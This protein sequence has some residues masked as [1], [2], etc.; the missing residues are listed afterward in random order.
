ML[1]KTLTILSLAGLVVSVGLWGVSYWNIYVGFSNGHD[2]HIQNGTVLFRWKIGYTVS[3]NVECRMLGFDNL[4]TYWLPA[5]SD[6]S[7]SGVIW[8][9]GLRNS[10]RLPLWIPADIFVAVLS[11][12]S[13]RNHQ[14]LK[15]GLC[16]KCGYD[17]RASTE[18][19]PE[20]GTTF[21]AAT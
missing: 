10:L 8:G 20:C 11:F 18:R 5:Y 14:R 12:L 17:L 21:K 7:K 4:D 3:G 2:V 15:L 9:G 16:L 19:C 1:R 13:L 6:N